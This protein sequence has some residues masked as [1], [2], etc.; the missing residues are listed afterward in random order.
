MSFQGKK[1]ILGITGSIAAYKSVFLTRLLIKAGA[2]VQVIMTPAA[3]SFVT[4]LTFSTIS[5]NPVHTDIFDDNGWN[6][7][8]ELGLWADIFVIAPDACIDREDNWL[9][10]GRSGRIIHSNDS[11]RGE[12]LS[13][14]E[15]VQR[16][17]RLVCDTRWL[18][19]Y[20][21]NATYC[22]KK[23]RFNEQ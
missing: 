12:A 23:S 1:I 10:G 18:P 21:Q 20:L 3:A 7:H 15:I 9:M 4:P 2:E 14:H 16:A 22:V 13:Y 5:K 11:T 6:N 8:V 17:R 19:K